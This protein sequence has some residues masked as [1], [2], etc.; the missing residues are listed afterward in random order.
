M[1]GEVCLSVCFWDVEPRTGVS[2]TA[3]L[4]AADQNAWGGTSKALYKG[5]NSLMAR[6]TTS[7]LSWP[8]ILTDGNIV[9]QNLP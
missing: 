6:L 3:W 8:S 5:V 2:R 7:P 1:T 4:P 9:G